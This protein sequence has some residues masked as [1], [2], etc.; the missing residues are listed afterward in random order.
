MPRTSAAMADL[1]A[2]WRVRSLITGLLVSHT[3]SANA[4]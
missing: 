4:A 3:R 1:R 2:N